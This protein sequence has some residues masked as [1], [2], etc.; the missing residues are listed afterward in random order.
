M[1]LLMN[2]CSLLKIRIHDLS[3][4]RDLSLILM[5]IEQIVQLVP[6]F[7][8]SLLRERS[9]VQIMGMRQTSI[10]GYRRAQLPNW[11]QYST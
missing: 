1:L 11:Y 2:F 9:W 8:L 3:L 5:P 6:G 4:R 10:K 7:S